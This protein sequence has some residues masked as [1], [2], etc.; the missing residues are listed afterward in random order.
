MLSTHLV[1]SKSIWFFGEIFFFI[2][3]LQILINGLRSGRRPGRSKVTKDSREAGI[4]DAALT[5]HLGC[6][7]PLSL[8]DK[9]HIYNQAY[10]THE[11]GSTQHIWLIF[12]VLC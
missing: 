6:K 11:D 1:L 4:A 8:L 2:L 3:L 7:Q 5:I 10:S 9:A 12:Y